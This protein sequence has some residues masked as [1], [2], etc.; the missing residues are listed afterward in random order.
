MLASFPRP[1]ADKSFSTIWRFF[2]LRTTKRAKPT[3][4]T[5]RSG[6]EIMLIMLRAAAP[7]KLTF[8]HRTVSVGLRV[9]EPDAYW[10]MR[11]Y[12]LGPLLKER[13]LVALSYLSR[14]LGHVLE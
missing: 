4:A 2:L 7:A 10:H 9:T 12:P 3:T 14:C 6:R 13:S 8:N 5:T 11:E 1:H